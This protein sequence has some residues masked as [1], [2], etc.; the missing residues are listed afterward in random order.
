MLAD[1]GKLE[2]AGKNRV[3]WEPVKRDSERLLPPWKQEDNL[4][5]KQRPHS[6]CFAVPSLM[7]L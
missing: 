7:F 4:E 5:Q 1:G 6:L 3:V 2:W